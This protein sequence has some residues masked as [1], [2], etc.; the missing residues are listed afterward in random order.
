VSGE[1]G[2]FDACCSKDAREAP[3]ENRVAIVDQVAHVFEKAVDGVGPVASDLFEELP[4][5]LMTD[6]CDLDAAGFQVDG[7]QHE[8]AHES[9]PR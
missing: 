3:G 2:G 7:K 6:V 8:I 1:L 4:V 5:G 9:C